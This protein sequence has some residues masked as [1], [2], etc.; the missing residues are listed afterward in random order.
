MAGTFAGYENENEGT[1]YRIA[2]FKVSNK[3][4]QFLKEDPCDQYAKRT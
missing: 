4:C 1:G 3:C 2:P